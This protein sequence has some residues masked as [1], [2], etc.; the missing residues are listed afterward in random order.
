MDYSW[1][2]I[3][4]SLILMYE[5]HIELCTNCMRNWPI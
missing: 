4:D 1:N 3:C 5:K 2:Q